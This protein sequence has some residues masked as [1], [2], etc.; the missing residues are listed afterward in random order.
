MWNN[1]Y[2]SCLLSL[3]N[4]LTVRRDILAKFNKHKNTLIQPEYISK[5]YQ[6]ERK[7]STIL[8]HLD[9][10]MRDYITVLVN[11][12]RKVIAKDLSESLYQPVQSQA[13]MKELLMQSMTNNESGENA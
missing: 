8:F 7:N 5:I 1:I 6:R 13:C 2:T 10:S 3:L 4:S 12:L 11:S 9:N